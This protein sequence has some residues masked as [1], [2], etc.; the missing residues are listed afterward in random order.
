MR[1]ISII[2]PVSDRFHAAT[3]PLALLVSQ[4]LAQCSVVEPY[5]IAVGLFMTT[6]ALWL[7]AP[8]KRFSPEPLAFIMMTVRQCIPGSAQDLLLIPHSEK[9]CEYLA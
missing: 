8:A 4:Y 6:F 1:L 3:T 9:Q 7:A 2:F 5:H